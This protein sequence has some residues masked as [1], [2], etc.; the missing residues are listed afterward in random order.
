MEEFTMRKL[1]ETFRG[2]LISLFD[3]LKKVAKTVLAFALGLLLFI[4]TPVEALLA[5]LLLGLF[6]I[7][8]VVAYIVVDIA[9]DY[10]D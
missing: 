7:V 3:G 9:K 6:I 2:L 4:V 10:M 5:L 8:I 1:Y